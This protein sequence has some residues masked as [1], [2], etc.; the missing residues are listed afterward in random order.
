[1]NDFAWNN[2]DRTNTAY[3]VGRRGSNNARTN[4]RTV[5]INTNSNSVRSFKDKVISVRDKF[6]TIVNN[7]NT[8]DEIIDRAIL[9]LK[10]NNNNVRIYTNPN[11]VP[12]NINSRVL[13]NNNSNNIRIYQRP[14][15]GNSNTPRNSFGR[16]NPT[17]VR[18]YSTPSTPSNSGRSSGGSISRGS[19]G[20]TGGSSRG[21]N[22]TGKIN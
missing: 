2:R 9:K 22:S 5:D 21:G 3:V 18:T 15:N 20:N 11:N 4:G 19:G 17:P 1:M 8:S 14:S 7:N 10:G 12:S 6:R 13:H 16:S